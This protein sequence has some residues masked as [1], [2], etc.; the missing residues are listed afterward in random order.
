MSDDPLAGLPPEGREFFEHCA[1]GRLCVQRCLE[2][3]ALRH[4]PRPLCT[5]CLSPRWEWVQCTGRGTL[6]TYTVIRQNLNPRF[7]DRLPYVVAVV[8]LEEGIRMLAGL[9]DAD[10]ERVRVGM[11]LVVDFATDV[12]GRVVPWFR[13][14]AA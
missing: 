4:Y 5:S 10:P 11:P 12:D 2:C 8:E 1:A 14:A 7:R 13:P 3:N 6:Y 9:R